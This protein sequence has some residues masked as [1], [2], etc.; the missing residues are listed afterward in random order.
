MSKLFSYRHT[1]AGGCNK[2]AF[3]TL[4]RPQ[5]GQSLA[6]CV[7][8]ST[9]GEHVKQVG[10]LM[11]GH[12]GNGVL[13]LKINDLKPARV[14]DTVD[15][16]VRALNKQTMVKAEL[17]VVTDNL[18]LLHEACSKMHPKD[19]PEIYK[20]SAL[21]ST[22]KGILGENDGVILDSDG[23]GIAAN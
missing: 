3:F 17:S 4:T 10:A 16:L 13:G 23:F 11:C 2:T 21:E 19:L 12:C 7:V 8:I 1:G 9:A 5:P 14:T 18:Q 6:E 15:L 22:I 20:G